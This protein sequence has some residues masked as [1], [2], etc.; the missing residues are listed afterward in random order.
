MQLCFM[1]DRIQQ[2]LQWFFTKIISQKLKTCLFSRQPD[3]MILVQIDLCAY[4]ISTLPGAV[5]NVE[6]NW[7]V[8][9]GGDCYY[10][11]V[12]HASLYLALRLHDNPAQQVMLPGEADTI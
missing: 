4:G 7:L 9:K 11:L 2:P 10:S 12:M 3:Q 1:L 8:L 6:P 5:D